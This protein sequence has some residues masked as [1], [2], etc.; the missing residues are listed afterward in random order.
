MT[1]VTW[2]KRYTM[3]PRGRRKAVGKNI[4]AAR[5]GLGWSQDELAELTPCGQPALSQI[6]SGHRAP[7]LDMLC[8]IAG[9]LRCSPSELLKGVR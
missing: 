5:E 8:N 4:C 2:F 6:E 1:S 7:S 3:T 9:A